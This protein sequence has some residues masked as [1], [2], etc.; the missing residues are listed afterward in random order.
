MTLDPPTTTN[1][2]AVVYGRALVTGTMDGHVVVSSCFVYHYCL[3]HVNG[4]C[5]GHM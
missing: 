2:C 5:T 3:L 1:T 4:T